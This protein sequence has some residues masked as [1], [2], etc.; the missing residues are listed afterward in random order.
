MTTTPTLLAH[1]RTWMTRNGWQ[2]VGQGKAG[3]LWSSPSGRSIA[4]PRSLE[5]DQEVFDGVVRRLA[6]SADIEADDLSRKLQNWSTD[7]AYVRAA[8]DHVVGNTIPLEAGVVLLDS[9]R[10]MFRAAASAAVRRRSA[11]AGNY[12]KRGNELAKQIRMDQTKSGSYIVPI[13]VPVGDRQALQLEDE[14]QSDLFRDAEVESVISIES[15]ERRMS[16]TFAEALTAVDEFVVR[17]VRS[18]GTD[19]ILQMI[20]RGVT[21]EFVSSI[22]RMLDE[23]AVASVDTTFEWAESQGAPK[24]MRKSISVPS[25]AA[26]LLN[27]TA[28]TLKQT[29]L[30]SVETFVGPIVMVA[31]E[32]LQTVVRFAI[33]TFRRNRDCRIESMTDTYSLEEVTDW[34][35]NETSVTVAGQVRRVAGALR[36]DKPSILV[37]AQFSLESRRPPQVTTGN[38]YLPGENSGAPKELEARKSEQTDPPL[39]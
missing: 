19:E 15:A 34:M 23:P 38:R 2:E 10:T 7:I 16:R 13:L 33:R 11:I 24:G 25:A 4:I 35:R 20:S 31:R 30:P 27:R 26:D 29:Q 8:N 36:I 32:P 37:A 18:P 28:E 21:R 3:W 9:T 12:S 39:A 14:K 17:P 22:G 5:A 6:D 1:V